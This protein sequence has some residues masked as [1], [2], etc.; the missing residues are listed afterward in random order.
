MPHA[1]PS[2]PR[3]CG[4]RRRR[5]HHRGAFTLIE[6][7]VAL[8]IIV[9]L[10]SIVV[11][12]VGRVRRTAQE[13]AVKAQIAALDQGIRSYYTTFT[14]YPGPLPEDQLGRGLTPAPT[15]KHVP[16]NQNLTNVTGSENLALA[17]LGGL[18]PTNPPSATWEFDPG[19]M[20]KGPRGLNPAN[21]KTY[22]AFI[23]GM[24]VT[25]TEAVGE[26]G[27]YQDDAGKADDSYIPE[28]LD[29]FP[30]P[31]PILY[32]R[33]RPGAAGVVSI[34]RKDSTG[35]TVHPADPTGVA[36]PTQYDLNPILG[37]TIGKTGGS[38]GEGKTIRRADYTKAPTGSVLPHGLQT[39]T[40]AANMDKGDNTNY[41]YPYD[42]FPYFIDRSHAPTDPTFPNRTGTPRQKDGFI[43]IS[44]GVDR[45]F[46]TPDDITN[47]G[48]V[49]E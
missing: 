34:Q 28:I 15:I 33:A 24:P 6:L 16:S 48:S 12:V 26:Y 8:G 29:K 44:A 20:S 27:R 35:A 3:P 18:R 30:S 41:A 43:L 13:T 14:A 38:I 11:P 7:L 2:R 31:L 1:T 25:Q 39:V 19:L 5:R 37:Y 9:V 21:P 4:D 23:E 42:A 10:V 46:G 49:N 47:F 36:P 22:T 32:L 40:P 45:V 17:L